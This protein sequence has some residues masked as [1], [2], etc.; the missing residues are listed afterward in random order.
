MI[1]RKV[2][3]LSALLAFAFAGCDSYDPF[4]PGQ[5]FEVTPLFFD[6]EF[7]ETQVL[8]ATLDGQPAQVSWAS[9]DPAIVSV[10][11]TGPSTAEVT[12]IAPG[13]AAVT[14]TL[15]SDPSRLRSASITVLPSFTMLRITG[16]ASSAPRFSTDEYQID[17]P[18]GL[19]NFTVTINGGTGD[20]DLIVISPSGAFCAPFLAGNNETCSFDD[21][22]PGTWDIILELWDPYTGVTLEARGT[23]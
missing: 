15:A 9:S 23:R 1:Y 13:T 17:V 8:T 16:L 5:A 14:A 11:Q 18:E 3:A 20:V 2:I 4:E 6:M 10:N 7:G 12:P 21:P 22:E 19:I